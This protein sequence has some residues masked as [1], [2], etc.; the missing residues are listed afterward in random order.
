MSGFIA[1]LIISLQFLLLLQ[2]HEH[3][4]KLVQTVS[5]VKHFPFEGFPMF[6]N[7]PWQIR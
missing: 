4:F 1:Q 7:L 5:F 6:L 3:T 2:H